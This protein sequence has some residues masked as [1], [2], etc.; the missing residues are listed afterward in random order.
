MNTTCCKPNTE[1]FMARLAR[2]EY[3]ELFLNVTEENVGN[4]FTVG[5]HFYRA[6]YFNF[7]EI[8]RQSEISIKSE[9]GG[10]LPAHMLNDFFSYLSSLSVASDLC[11]LPLEL[12]RVMFRLFDFVHD[13]QPGESLNQTHTACYRNV[14]MQIMSDSYDRLFVRLERQIYNLD[15]IHRA[16]QLSEV[17]VG[18]LKRHRFSSECT[19]PL[20]QLQNCGH[21]TGYSKFKPCLFYCMNVLRGCFADVADIHKEFRLLTKALSDIPDDILGTFQPDVFIKDSLT[22]LVQLVKDLRSIDLREEVATACSSE[23]SSSTGRRSLRSRRLSSSFVTATPATAQEEDRLLAAFNQEL[24][25]ME[26]IGALLGKVPEE[27]CYQSKQHRT[28]ADTG[29][30]RCWLGSRMGTYRHSE[31]RFTKEDQAH[32]PEFPGHPPYLNQ[33]ND[34]SVDIATV[35]AEINETLDLVLCLDDE[36]CIVAPFYLCG[37]EEEDGLDFLSGSGSGEYKSERGSGSGS[38]GSVDDGLRDMEDGDSS[39]PGD[40]TSSETDVDS[41]TP[42]VYPV[43]IL[44]SPLRN[45]TRHFEPTVGE[46]YTVLNIDPA[47]NSNTSTPVDA[48]TPEEGAITPDSENINGTEVESTTTNPSP[49]IAQLSSALSL[50]LTSSLSFLTAGAVLVLKFT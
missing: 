16:M 41:P 7:L 46:D 2:R 10:K 40:G 50:E 21:C 20:T 3:G 37:E 47:D 43:P 45:T 29:N 31:V 49:E 23:S 36:D 14:S 48:T 13:G 39:S 30:H 38:G 8:R 6:I 25:C 17:V 28:I 42:D 27:M 4:C 22:H 32:N 5:R 44:D 1:K 9:L 18:R 24:H 19:K 34:L 11:D 12:N 33:Y 15:L 35:T 26:E